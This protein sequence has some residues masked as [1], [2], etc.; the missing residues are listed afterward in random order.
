SFQDIATVIAVAGGIA[1]AHSVIRSLSG[2]VTEIQGQVAAD[3]VNALV[4]G[5]AVEMDLE[6][7]ETPAYYDMLTRA[8]QGGAGRPARVVANLMHVGQNSLTLIAVGGLLLSIHWMVVVILLAATLPSLLIRFRFVK[9]LYEWTRRR[10][11]LE[12]EAYYLQWL[13]SGDQPAKEIR[14]FGLGKP[15]LDRFNMLRTVLRQERIKISTRRTVQETV[16]TSAGN[17]AF[18]VSAGYVAY[19][20]FQGDQ[21]IGDLVLFLQTF[22][23]GQAVLQTLL[24][25]ITGL[26]EDGLYVSN[27]F[28]LFDLKNRIVEAENP[29]PLP[30]PFQQGVAFDQVSF[31]YPGAQ[32][33]A[34]K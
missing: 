1:I 19:G 4:L 24:G 27:I 18:Y 8:Q 2:L 26:Y 25:N 16:I 17:A 23:R 5:R 34:L 7:Y 13:I 21:T 14:L 28:E 10:V 30:V 29:L 3:Y 33:D 22:Q 9:L 11:R 15:L 20:V 32:R 6:F 12:R 31:R